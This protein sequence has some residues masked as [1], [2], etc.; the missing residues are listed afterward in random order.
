[1]RKTIALVASVIA[2]IVG[3]MPKPTVGVIGG[4]TVYGFAP[5]DTEMWLGKLV[6]L[7]AVV[8]ALWYLSLSERFRGFGR[9]RDVGNGPA[10]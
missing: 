4:Q 10:S 1:M 8:A 5:P 6:G 3:F 7:L 9:R 2:I